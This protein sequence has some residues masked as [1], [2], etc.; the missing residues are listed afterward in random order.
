MKRGGRLG[1]VQAAPRD[2]RG[3]AKLLDIHWFTL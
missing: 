2:L 1:D 3:V